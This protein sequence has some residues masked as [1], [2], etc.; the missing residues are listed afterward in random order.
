[1]R[2]LIL[3]DTAE[4]IFKFKKNL[5]GAELF[6]TDVPKECIN[7]LINHG[8]WDYLFLD[9]DMGNIFMK[10]GDG[11]GYE[12][13]KYLSDHPLLTPSRVII[14][15]M[16]NIGAA[17]MMRVLGDAGIR[18][19]YVPCAWDLVKIENTDRVKTPSY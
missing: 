18:A 2:I 8:P 4:R 11:T 14:H 7:Q 19:K 5:E 15:S 10:P 3:E 13:A 1:M 9:H 6:I 17:A 16:N 12:V